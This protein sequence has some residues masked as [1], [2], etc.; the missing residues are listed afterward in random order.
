MT[1]FY[2]SYSGKL[3]H[4]DPP[5]PGYYV[6]EAAL[7]TGTG[8]HELN[9][10]PDATQAQAQAAA[11]ALHAG[12]PAQQPDT[13]IGQLTQNAVGQGASKAAQTV[14]PGSTGVISEAG[15][16]IKAL[17][18]GKMW[19]SLGWML[20]GVL[21]IFIGLFLWVGKEA[22][23]AVARAVLALWPLPS[24]RRLAARPLSR[25]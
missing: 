22:V 24:A 6:Y 20:L 14:V 5:A 19:R 1:W 8:W 15:V 18:D 3:V 21:L 2:N 7:K 13:S 11:D 10:S 17:T 16:F 25:W 9:V 4:E 12:A 23:P